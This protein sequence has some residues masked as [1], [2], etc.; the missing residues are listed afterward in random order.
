MR[1]L[2]VSNLYPPYVEG[3]AEI[4]AHDMAT[5]LTKLGHEVLTLTSSYG[6]KKARKDENV[7]R[8]LRIFPVAHF[9]TR[10]SVLQQ[11]NQLYNFYRRY[12]CAANARELRRVIAETKPDVLYIW[13]VTGIGVTSLMKTLSSLQIPI[14]FHLGSYWL[15]FASKPETEQSRFKASALKQRL[16]G[17]FPIPQHASMIAVS[18]TVKQQHVEGGIDAARIEVIYNGIDASFL[19]LPEAERTEKEEEQ[20]F[21]LLY[22]G[23]LR[24]IG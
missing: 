20:P 1:I 6:L 18:E 24:K 15:L 8:T 12:H 19:E 13:E 23:R 16:I 10:R 3:G 7:W 17:A 14:V 11:F 2:L 5:E 22:V 9:D 4:L 21:Q